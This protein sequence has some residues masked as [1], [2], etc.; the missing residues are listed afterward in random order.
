M[1]ATTDRADVEHFAGRHHLSPALRDGGP[2]LVAG[3]DPT[4][5][6]CGWAPFFRAMSARGLALAFEPDD[7]T[8][9]RFVDRAQ[10][11]RDPV[12]RA[13]LARSLEDARRFFAAVFGGTGPPPRAR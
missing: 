11:R 6:R 4:A 3:P 7:P 5:T 12:H 1:P 9:A 10:A 2:V 8:S 13:S